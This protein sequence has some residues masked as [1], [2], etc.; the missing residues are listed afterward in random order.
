MAN[1]YKE[2]LK[3]KMNS[4]VHSIFQI[5]KNFPREETYIATSQI[6]RAALSVILNYVEGFARFK[7][8]NQLQF[9]E[10]SYGSLKETKYLLEF[11]LQ[12][13]FLNNDNYNIAH[14]QIDEIGAMLWTEIESLNKS[15]N[16]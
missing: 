13:K 16:N 8:G 1:N 6:K 10:I 7:K 12:E 5:T 15:I 4:L 3:Q 9:L 2:N 11:S 14:K